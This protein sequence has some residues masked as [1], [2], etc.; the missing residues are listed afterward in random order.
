MR[1]DDL[2]FDQNG[3]LKPYGPISTNMQT[4]EDIF[5]YNEQRKSI[6]AA[7]QNFIEEIR[8]IYAGNFTQWV[9]GSFVTKKILPKDI[10]IVTFLPFEIIDSQKNLFQRDRWKLMYVDCFFERVFPMSHPMS[11]IS[12]MDKAEWNA[13]FSTTRRDRSTFKRYNKGFLQINF[14]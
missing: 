6:F 3:F 1:M 7:Y 8:A 4:L 12:K 9:N 14:E 5:V 11:N 10:D 13:L 2:S